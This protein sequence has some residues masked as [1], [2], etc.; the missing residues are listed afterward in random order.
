MCVTSNYLSPS[1]PPTPCPP[2]FCD[3]PALSPRLSSF[4]KTTKSWA[5]LAMNTC[6]SREPWAP[7]H[8]WHG[9][10]PRHMD[11]YLWYQFTFISSVKYFM[12]HWS[13]ISSAVQSIFSGEAEAPAENKTYSALRKAVC[14][15]WGWTSPVARLHPAVNA[16]SRIYSNIRQPQILT[17]CPGHVHSLNKLLPH[18]N[19]LK[20]SLTTASRNSNGPKKIFPK[21]LLTSLTTSIQS[22]PQESTYKLDH[23]QASHIDEI[24]NWRGLPCLQDCTHLLASPHSFFL[25]FAKITFPLKGMEPLGT[26]SLIELSGKSM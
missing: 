25:A 3:G 21:A 19:Y 12:K 13:L 8:G 7:P 15:M 2:S 22:L 1:P 24:P 16:S 5:D 6:P 4:L 10:S 11:T 18:Q 20:I 14:A 17:I 23:T 9:H 26:Q